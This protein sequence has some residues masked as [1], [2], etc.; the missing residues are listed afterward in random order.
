MAPATAPATSL[1]SSGK[2]PGLREPGHT[3]LGT[4]GKWSATSASWL[5]K[6]LYAREFTSEGDHRSAA[7]AV[8]NIHHTYHRP[9]GAAAGKP[10][11]ARLRE[12]VTDVEPSYI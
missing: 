4:T 9:H 5:R 8:W 6:S 2:A 1:A 11:A 10:P 12:S 3:H 7:I